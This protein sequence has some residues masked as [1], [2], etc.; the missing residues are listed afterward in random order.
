MPNHMP[1]IPEEEKVIVSSIDAR[2]TSG[3]DNE[4]LF[5]DKE[6]HR[7]RLRRATYIPLLAGRTNMCDLV[8]EL[9]DIVES[10]SSGWNP[11]EF[12][13]AATSTLKLTLAEIP[14]VKE[15]L[16]KLMVGVR[17]KDGSF[18]LLC[19][20]ALSGFDVLYP[21]TTDAFLRQTILFAVTDHCQTAVQAAAAVNYDY[22]RNKS[23]LSY[24]L[25]GFSGGF[26]IG[27]LWLWFK[28]QN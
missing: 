14:I 15:R 28:K 20:Y 16:D 9:M 23:R 7:Q 5:K 24:A 26:L 1:M 19:Q 10:L 25:V 18:R 2:T 12:D 4:P 27:G 8:D 3:E 11:K 6:L 13:E 17:D 21:I 22:Y